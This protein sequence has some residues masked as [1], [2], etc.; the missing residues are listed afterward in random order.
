MELAIDD[1]SVDSLQTKLGLEGSAAISMGFGV[2]VPQAGF[3][4]VH[5]FENDRQHLDARFAQDFRPT[6]TVFTFSTDQPDR[7]YFNI[8]AGVV[9]VLPRGL[10]VFGQF[11]TLVGHKFFDSVG[12]SVGVRTEF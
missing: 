5:E 12:G 11:R 8:T 4:W 3:D 10:Q 6:P 7:D 1:W 9:A 2:L